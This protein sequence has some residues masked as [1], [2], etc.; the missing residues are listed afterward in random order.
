MIRSSNSR[1]SSMRPIVRTMSSRRIW[2]MR[3]PGSSMFCCAIAWRTWPIDNP[4]AVRR[5]GST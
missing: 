1:T 2:S 3:P 4:W 5:S